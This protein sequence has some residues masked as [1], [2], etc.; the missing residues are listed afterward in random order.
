MALSENKS[1]FNEAYDVEFLDCVVDKADD[2]KI[3]SSDTHFSEFVG[4][5]PSKIKQGKLYLQDILQPIDRQEILKKICRKNAKYVY[6][7]LNLINSK[8]EST[9]VHCSARNIENSTRC[10]L[11]F[12]NVTK[13]VEKEKEL[14]TEAN[15]IS[16]L[17]DLVTG[18]VCLFKV[19][20]NMHFEAQYMNQACC[21]YF[22]TTKESYKQRVYRIDELIHQEDKTLVYQAIGKSMATGKP[23]DMEFRVLTHKDQVTWCKCNAAIQRYDD[24]GCPIFHA[25]FTDITAIKKAEAKVDKLN[26]QLINLL[27]NL[28]GSIFF[29]KPETPFLTICTSGDFIRFLGYS[30]AEFADRFNNDISDL[31]VGNTEKLA[32]SIKRDVFKN[33]KSTVTYQISRKGS[34]IADVTDR[35]KLITHS[36]GTK[37]LMCE[38]EVSE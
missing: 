20:K 10:R 5:H 18:G 14:E 38:I 17:I 23:F 34:R 22:G 21:V 3:V 25:M 32:E 2:F 27:E 8:G 29:S 33:G 7:N 4:V 15:E 26:E 31:I 19:T 16:H 24:D 35:R 1:D 9:Y 30:R 36:D 11:V 28:S 6:M 37:V 12:A 13:N